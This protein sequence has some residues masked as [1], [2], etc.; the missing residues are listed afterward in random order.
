MQTTRGMR[1]EAGGGVDLTEN[2]DWGR[3]ET[4]NFDVHFD[5]RGCPHHRVTR[6]GVGYWGGGRH[7][8]RGVQKMSKRGPI[9]Q[10]GGGHCNIWGSKRPEV[11]DFS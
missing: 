2:G 6:R 4:P 7:Q 10:M 11:L 9:F 5:V 8:K 3:I 1:P